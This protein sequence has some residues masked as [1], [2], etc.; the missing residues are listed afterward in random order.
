MIQPSSGFDRV[1]GGQDD[2][3]MPHPYSGS[4]LLQAPNPCMA[5]DFSILNSM[6]FS[7]GAFMQQGCDISPRYDSRNQLKLLRLVWSCSKSMM[8]NSTLQ[9]VTEFSPVNVELPIFML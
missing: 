6:W 1:I 4:G 9:F 5:N 2:L 7:L 3:N 8:R